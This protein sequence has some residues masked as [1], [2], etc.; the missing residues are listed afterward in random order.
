MCAEDGSGSSHELRLQRL[1]K[2]R[3]FSISFCAGAQGN[4]GIGRVAT[5]C[6]VKP[7]RHR[8]ARW[9][10]TKFSLLKAGTG[11]VELRSS[12][13]PHSHGF[14]VTHLNRRRQTGRAN[15]S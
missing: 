9:L 3:I 13:C 8:P 1:P 4:T 2:L 12:S 6:S 11:D 15:L 14:Q 7:I 5:A 10:E